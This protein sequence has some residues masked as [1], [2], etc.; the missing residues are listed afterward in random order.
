MS[1][2]N[3]TKRSNLASIKDARKEQPKPNAST[4]PKTS[5]G[6]E[7][8]SQN[9]QT[10]G[11]TNSYP[12]ENGRVPPEVENRIVLPDERAEDWQALKNNWRQ[13][14]QPNTELHSTLVMQAIVCEWM[15]RR[16]LRRY[17]EMEQTLYAEQSD[18]TQWTLEQHASLERFL[19]YH[20]KAERAFYRAR[21]A[22]ERLRC[23]AKQDA[24]KASA[25]QPIPSGP[26]R[27]TPQ[28]K[29]PGPSTPD[30][31][32]TEGT[33]QLLPRKPGAL[34]Q[35][36]T[37]Q[38]LEGKTFT[39]FQPRSEAMAR[40]ILNSREPKPPVKRALYF[41]DGIPA[42][43]E[44]ITK[45]DTHSGRPHYVITRTSEQALQDLERERAD[46]SGHVL[47]VS[48]RD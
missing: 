41:L 6:K 40:L 26:A 3:L 12:I 31:A 24:E 1:V 21:H 32:T 28:T 16:T 8:A 23:E 19:R 22:L 4:G 13:E 38:V 48:D 37:V 36:I 5:A 44:W 17:N 46:G 10:H 30:S 45:Y 14:Y 27:Q 35:C 42:E 25:Q 15:M 47:L 33:V 43:Y 29:P 2:V 18:A 20:T 11:C 7:K 34:I 39:L 9:S